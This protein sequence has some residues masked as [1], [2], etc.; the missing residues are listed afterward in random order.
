[1][2]A[3]V[4]SSWIASAMFCATVGFTSTFGPSMAMRSAEP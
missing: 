1:L 3:F 2:A 4:A